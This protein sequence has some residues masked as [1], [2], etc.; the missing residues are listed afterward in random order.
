MLDNETLSQ[1]ETKR[2]DY[3][4]RSHRKQ[5]YFACLHHRYFS[6]PPELGSTEFCCGNTQK[7]EKT[8]KG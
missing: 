7:P 3:K 4:K 5:P 8:G 2:Y 1:K 6:I